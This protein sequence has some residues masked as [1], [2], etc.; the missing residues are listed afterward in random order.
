M[1]SVEAVE[2]I[3][4]GIMPLEQIQARTI[5]IA[6]DQYKPGQNE[7]KI[8]FTSMKSFYEVL[9]DENQTLLKMILSEHPNSIAA[10]V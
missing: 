9:S 4:I 5:A 10:V 6:S 3:K 7:P 1:K 8:W 2:A